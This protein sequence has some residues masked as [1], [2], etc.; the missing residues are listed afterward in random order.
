[1][2]QRYKCR[3][4]PY[5]HQINL[6]AQA[7]GCARIVWNDAL[8]ESNKLYH[9][10]EKAI[11][12]VLLKR[13]ITD[14][15]KTKERQ[16]LSSV[17][18][19]VLQQS[20]RDLNQ[21][22]KNWFASLKGKRKGIRKVGAPQ[23]KKRSNRQSIRFT[24]RTF[25]I[26]ERTVSLLKIGK[27][28]IVFSQELPSPP[29][30]VTII[31][32][33]AGR[34]FA[35]FVVETEPEMLPWDTTAV[36][37]DLG[38]ETLATLSSGEKIL[39][40]KFFRSAQKRLRRLQRNLKNKQR[41]SNRLERARLRVAKLHARIADQRH[42]FLHKLSTK[43]IRENQTIVLE[44][45]AVK[46]MLGNRRL[47][48][49]IADAG[50]RTLR[51]MLEAKAQMYGRDVIIINRWTPT[52]QLCSTCGA[53]DG[54]KPLDVRSWK[55]GS[56]GTEHDRDVNAALNILAAGLAE[57]QNGRGAT[58]ETSLEAAGCEASTHLKNS[59]ALNA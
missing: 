40:P 41:G 39:P 34:Y 44:D 48:K 56:C 13:C 51:T 6:L 25:K 55:C 1:M 19:V 31:K 52:S 15:K 33:R 53:Q 58:H 32:D 20:V 7:F 18:A 9:A 49:S 54:K 22:F 24:K 16:W 50:W 8:A 17:P 42:D 27:V 11:G 2:K 10:G 57:S 47:S 43:L 21:A 26:N 4:Y 23:F 46:N 30:S 59:L 3:L 12:N 35:S 5:P 38:L 14:A 37:V 29:S 36:G 45:L 28:P